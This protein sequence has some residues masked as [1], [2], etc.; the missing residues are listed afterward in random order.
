[1]S[2]NSTKPTNPN[3]PLDDTWAAL[4]KYNLLS[5][6]VNELKLR[7]WVEGSGSDEVSSAIVQ[8]ETELS[9]FKAW[10]DFRYQT[11]RGD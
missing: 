1:M 4:T 7:A 3:Q 9:K 5:K 6:Q 8:A 10:I 11:N 2:S